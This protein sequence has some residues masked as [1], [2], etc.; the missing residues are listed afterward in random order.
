[1][2]YVHFPRNINKLFSFYG[3][4]HIRV[5]IAR[6]ADRINEM[7]IGKWD[8]RN[9]NVFARPVFKGVIIYGQGG[10]GFMLELETIICS[11]NFIKRKI[12]IVATI[13]GGSLHNI[14]PTHFVI[15]ADKFGTTRTCDQSHPRV[16]SILAK[17]APNYF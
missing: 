17:E 3:N 1:V 16:T 10:K 13:E 2:L 9:S 15:K 14:I 4:E 5:I 6:D 12:G 8:S 11:F 7:D